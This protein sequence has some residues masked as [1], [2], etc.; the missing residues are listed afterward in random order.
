MIPASMNPI[1]VPEKRAAI[2]LTVSGLTALQ[3]A[4]AILLSVV[5]DARE[6]CVS[7]NFW[8]KPNASLGGRMLRTQ[9]AFCA[10]SASE[11]SSAALSAS[12]TSIIFASCRQ[13]RRDGGSPGQIVRAHVIHGMSERRRE[14]ILSSGKRGVRRTRLYANLSEDEYVDAYGMRSGFAGQRDV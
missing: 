5:V 13:I 14:I 10:M 8:A 6:V 4:Y 7:R 11:A 3:S 9:L 1:G 2:R 12:Q